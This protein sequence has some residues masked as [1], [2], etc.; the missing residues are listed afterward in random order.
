MIEIRKNVPMPPP[1][2]PRGPGC[3]R[4]K[5]PFEL[6]EV[7]DSF[8]IEDGSVDN[9][10][11]RVVAATAGSRHGMKFTCRSLRNEDNEVYGIGVWRVE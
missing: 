6:M 3:T 7:G 5:Y 11:I 2:T 9:S 1:W 8:V 10:T 4:P